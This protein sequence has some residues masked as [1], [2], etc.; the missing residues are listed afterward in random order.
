M[1]FLNFAFQGFWHFVGCAVP[2][3][4]CRQLHHLHGAGVFQRAAMMMPMREKMARAM[5]DCSGRRDMK[6]YGGRSA[7]TILINSRAKPGM[8]VSFGMRWPTPHST[9]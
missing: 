9:R 3:D 7:P 2:A 8:A 5:Y 6:L 4:D 1:D